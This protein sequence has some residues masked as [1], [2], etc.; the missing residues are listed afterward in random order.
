[1]ELAADFMLIAGSMLAVVAAV[2]LHRFD[3]VVAR[4]HAA[5]KP[6]TL[7]LVLI[8][9]GAALRLGDPGDT[10]L[11][12]LVLV[13]QFITAPIGAHLIGRAAYRAVP[14]VR[15]SITVDE[16]AADLGDHSPPG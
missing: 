3:N 14:E 15:K 12:V 8:L 4:M 6:A 13:F 7:G 16:L 1:M 10:V 5:T 9:T 2:G 11:L